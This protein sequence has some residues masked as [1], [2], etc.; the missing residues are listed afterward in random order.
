MKKIITSVDEATSDVFDGAVIA[1]GGFFSAGR[2]LEFTKALAK[3]GV[4]DLTVVVQQVG[5]GNEERLE[6][7]VNGQIK[8]AI[9]NY[10]L[11][12]AKLIVA[13]DFHEMEL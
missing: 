4:E 10:L 3:K 8:K 13:D 6:L 11:T 5:T 1:F 7:V 12:A 9:C 2:P